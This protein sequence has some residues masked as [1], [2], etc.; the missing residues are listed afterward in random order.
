MKKH[1]KSVRNES[2]LLQC[3][4]KSELRPLPGLGIPKFICGFQALIRSD[5]E[6]A[7]MGCEYHR[8]KLSAQQT[9]G[10][11]DIIV[12][13][14]TTT[15]KMIRDLFFQYENEIEKKYPPKKLKNPSKPRLY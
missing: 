8:T 10:K 11:I 7:D 3:K 9:L 5:K 15:S 12:R 14:S 13:S 2:F 6:I 4:Q 1:R